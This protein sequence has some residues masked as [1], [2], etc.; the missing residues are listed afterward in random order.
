M[1]FDPTRV[2]NPRP[3]PE[4]LLC[5]KC[6]KVMIEPMEEECQHP[7]CRLCLELWMVA[8]QTC[9]AAGCTASLNPMYLRPAH[10]SIRNRLSAM[11]VTCDNAFDGCEEVV[12][13]QALPDHL[14]VCPKAK[15][16]CS[17]DG[18][19]E[20]EIM[21]EVLYQHQEGCQ[22]R[23][24]TCNLCNESMKQGELQEHMAKTCPNVEVACKHNGGCGR[25]VPRGVLAHHVE[26]ACGRAIVACTIPGC[27]HM[28]ARGDLKHHLE[29]AVPHH[30]AALSAALQLQLSVNEEQERQQQAAQAA[31]LALRVE[32]EDI[33]A[34]HDRLRDRVRELQA[35]LATPGARDVAID[36]RRRMDVLWRA[37]T[38]ACVS[39]LH[40]TSCVHALVAH[41]GF[42]YSCSA[43]EKEIKVWSGDTFVCVA[44]MEGH[45]AAV[46]ALAAADGVVYS[47]SDDA[48]IKVWATDARTCTAT[49]RG[50]TGCVSALVVG[51]GVLFSATSHEIKAWDL[52]TQACL[53]TMTGH[54]GWVNTMAVGGGRLFSAS[55]CDNNIKVW[56]T[57]DYRPQEPLSGHTETISSLVVADDLLYSGSDDHTIRIWSLADNKCIRQMTIPTAAAFCLARGKGFFYAGSDTKTIQVW[58][59]NA[60]SYHHVTSLTGHFGYVSALAVG[61]GFL[62]S[63]SNDGTIKVC[64]CMPYL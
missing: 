31:I 36:Y 56:D 10:R 38:Y 17:H 24:V 60:V 13:F 62:Y 34:A 21:R 50:H 48:M 33:W 8:N 44:V 2:L 3:I 53:A 43:A 47:G 57:T 27:G 61:E 15:V 42:L 26:Q 35:Q 4:D 18:C 1:G 6:S 11:E 7:A 54:T 5:T 14:S 37:A 64:T 49:L 30:M 23:I 51:N 52:S 32:V 55:R 41:G 28:V 25:M 16:P 45:E 40:Q 63:A 12:Q 9:P 20:A 19:P 46:F 22:Y 39:T 29:V 58:S 59:T